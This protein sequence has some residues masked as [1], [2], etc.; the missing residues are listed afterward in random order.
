MVLYICLVPN[1][2][3]RIGHQSDDHFRV[4]TYC[5]KN[6]FNYVYHPF[7]CNSK[8]FENIL[9][10]SELYEN[11]YENIFNKIEFKNIFALKDLDNDLMFVHNKLIE[12]HQMDE[13]ILLFDH[14]CGN[15]SYYKIFNITNDD[16]I[17]T[18]LNYRGKLLHHYPNLCET[19]YV[20]IHVRRG[21]IIN[22]KSRYLDVDYFIDKY[23]ELL[24][25][26]N[27]PVYIITE[28]NFNDDELLSNKI[29]GCN[30]IKSDEI[31]SF[32]YLVHCKYLIA[33]RSGFSNLS[34][35]LGHMKV[36][37]P[38][39]DWNCYYDNLFVLTLT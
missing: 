6:L 14:I 3:A 30:I 26:F 19:D 36:V 29:K 35:I 21:D 2:G 15:E 1:R 4:V 32:Y 16:V 9:K 11:H 20:A 13:N 37:K 17:K 24:A 25:E 8:S 12:L 27:L 7:T 39:N 23:N 18:K 22:D 31:T 10:F 28:N 38:P 5:H 34:Y 33:S